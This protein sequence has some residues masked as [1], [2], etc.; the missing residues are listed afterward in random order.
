MKILN[1]LCEESHFKS[2]SQHCFEIKHA[3]KRYLRRYTDES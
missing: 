1:E 2:L 3:K